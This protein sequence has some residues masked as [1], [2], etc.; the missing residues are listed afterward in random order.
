MVKQLFSSV[1]FCSAARCHGLGFEVVAFHRFR[2][3]VLE[4]PSLSVGRSSLKAKIRSTNPNFQQTF[5]L[6][7]IVDP[8]AGALEHTAAKPPRARDPKIPDAGSL[9][10]FWKRRGAPEED[11]SEVWVLW[12]CGFGA[13]G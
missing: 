1:T 12:A 10:S 11:F 4:V 6:Q 5:L 13:S 9:R 3:L 7:A 2:G 8:T